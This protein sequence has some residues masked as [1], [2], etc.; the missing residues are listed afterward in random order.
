MDVV[1]VGIMVADVVARPV[2]SIP[3]KGSLGLVSAIELHSGGCA[4][5]TGIALSKIGIN[6]AVI[7]KVGFDP[8]GDFLINTC[9]SNKVYSAGIVRSKTVGTSAT[10]VLVDSH[11]ERTFIHYPGANNELK[12]NEI[13]L[14]PYRKAKILHLAG[15]LLMH[16]LDGA[17]SAR[18][19]KDAKRMGMITSL[20]TA[21][22]STGRWMKAIAPCLP[23]TD[24]FMAGINEARMITKKNNPKEI[25]NALISK[26][27]KTVALKM[28]AKGS[29]IQS[30]NTGFFIPAFKVKTIET[31]GAG[32]AFVAGFLV[33]TL[34]RWPIEKTGRFANAVGAL[35]T[36][37]MGASAGVKSLKET[38][39]FI[40]AMLSRGFH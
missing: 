30:G 10:T 26:G 37:A 34:K 4:V 31:T 15:S 39:K 8:F 36:M 20:D 38:D 1:C 25:A 18:L 12:Y 22:D 16:K 13:N 40:T 32:D 33:G 2:D 11:G 29:Y 17:P 14:K 19:L 24:I 3:K 35:S 27:V 23:Y 7:G 28:G 5:N 9:K 21:W 6:S